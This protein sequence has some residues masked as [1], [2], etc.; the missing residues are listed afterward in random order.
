[1]DHN[2]SKRVEDTSGVRSGLFRQNEV[3]VESGSHDVV[4]AELRKILVEEATVSVFNRS[5]FLGS[6]KHH[7]G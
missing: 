6:G 1:M 2:A 3:A 7:R 4:I 5:I